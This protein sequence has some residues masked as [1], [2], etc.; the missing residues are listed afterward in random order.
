MSIATLACH[1]VRLPLATPFV[2]AQRVATHAEAV[3]VR[4]VDDDGVTGWGEAVTTWRVTGESAASVAAAVDGPLGDAVLGADPTDVAAWAPAL[5]HAVVGNAAARS[6]VAGALVDVAARRTGVPLAEF[7]AGTGRDDPGRPP[8]AVRTDITLSAVRSP[9]ELDELLTRAADQAQAF[10]TLKVK[11]VDAAVTRVALVELRRAV[12]PGVRLRVD[13][14]QAWDAATAVAVLEYWQHHGADVE[15]VEQPVAAADLPALAAVRAAGLTA[16]LADEAVHTVADVDALV[17]LDAADGINVK[18]AKSGGPVQALLLADR[19][20]A[21]G[22]DVLVGCMMESTVGLAASVAVA[23]VLD[24]RYGT[25][26]HDLDAGM[27]LAARDERHVRYDGD[28]LVRSD[29]PG[30]GLPPDGALP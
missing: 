21:H 13:A 28:V 2:T 9:A 8:A 25:R 29:E 7:L 10:G 18:L 4:A 3:L 16:V 22:L 5:E 24:G 23:A 11:V 17:R 15:L 6:A 20:R 27:W 26:V 1:P 30:I 19:A 12:G 14:N